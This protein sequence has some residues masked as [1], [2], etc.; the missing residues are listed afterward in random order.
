MKLI[1][2]RVDLLSVVMLR[3][4]LLSVVRLSVMAPFFIYPRITSPALNAKI[5]LGY[6]F[7]LAQKL[8]YCAKC[9][10]TMKNIMLSVVRLSVL[11]SFYIYLRIQ[12]HYLQRLD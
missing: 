5:R 12:L 6:K 3:V 4:A 9:N 2:L 10:A 8:A 11:V 1:M 7:I